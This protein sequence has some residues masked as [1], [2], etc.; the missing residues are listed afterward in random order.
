MQLTVIQALNSWKRRQFKY[1][2][3]DCC[4]F[5]SHVLL[6]LTGKDYIQKF[7][8]DTEGAAEQILA[9]HGG[10]EGLV[11]YALQE[12]PSDNFGDG[13]PVI[14]ELPIIG[15]AMGIKLGNEVV[16]LTQK[17]MTKV[18]ARYIFRGWKICHQ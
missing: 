17:G 2:D 10:L 7:G 6:E 16:C 8:Y 1:G 15:Q 9:E 5:V 3:S 11:S 13:D 18:S 4:Q 12:S 14:V